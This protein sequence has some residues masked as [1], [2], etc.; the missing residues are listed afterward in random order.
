MNSLLAPRHRRGADN[1]SVR[2]NMQVG[3]ILT[4]SRLDDEQS[5]AVIEFAATPKWL[6]NL[7]DD[8]FGFP[9]KTALGTLW[10]GVDHE[11]INRQGQSEFIRAV[12]MGGA[13]LFY[14]EM[15]AEFEDTDVNIRDNRGRTA[16]HWVSAMNHANMVRL[17]LSVPECQIGLKDNDGLT[18]FD[19]SLRSGN[20]IIATSFYKNMFEIQET[21]PQAA[22]LRVL[23]V[24]SEPAS[25]DRQVFPG[26]A[27]FAPIEDSNVP[28]VKALI[29]RGVDLTV[30][31]EGGDTPLH[32][33]TRKVDNVEVTT[34]LLKAGSEVNAKRNGGATPLHYAAG[35]TDEKKVQLLL[36]HGAD[37]AIMDIQGQ[38][39]RDL[40]E[41]SQHHGVLALLRKVDTDSMAPA[42]FAIEKQEI[43]GE[44]ISD[45]GSGDENGDTELYRAV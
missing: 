25:E 1:R 3:I 6:L 38:T 7:N 13:N 4:H 16:L 11:S 42:K 28:L 39:A 30:T 29:E 35:T 18:A 17:C 22:L 14:A 9:K 21:H 8:P 10:R 12:V 23:T 15:L 19:I 36:E 32:V 31:N 34:M 2:A 24:S 26:I 43:H 33:A 5:V 44:S 40:A 37:I 20:K 45:I 27:L 41:E